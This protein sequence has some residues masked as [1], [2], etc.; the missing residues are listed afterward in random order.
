VDVTRSAEALTERSTRV[1]SYAKLHRGAA[2][3]KAGLFLAEGANSVDA[4]LATDRATVL[5]VTADAAERHHD[6]V[7][8]AVDGGVEVQEITARA[9]DKLSESVTA[10]GLFA[11]CRLLDASLDDVLA[12]SPR[13]LAV[14]VEGSEPGNVGTL[15]RTA[16]ALGADAVVLAGD[17]VDPH[18][19]KSVRASAGSI[20]HIP[21]VRAGDPLELLDR[22]RAVGVTTCATTGGGEVPLPEADAVL[23][24]AVAW[25]FGNEAHGLPA[26]VQARAD[27][28]ISIPIQDGAESL[29]LAAAASICLYT[30][31]RAHAD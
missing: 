10:P 19:G 11:V 30:S 27:H 8:R 23:R 21:V 1:V 29:N 22:L 20:F 17:S 6:L 7:Q 4:A 13:L 25:L 2:R 24:G 12:H 5:L 15:I 26:E 16:A 14:A 9:A 28:R 3:R 31:S 18:N